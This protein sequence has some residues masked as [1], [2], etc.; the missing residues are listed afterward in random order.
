[1]KKLIVPTVLFMIGIAWF[2][3]PIFFMPAPVH[4]EYSAKTEVD[5]PDM[6]DNAVSNAMSELRRR[7]FVPVK[8]EVNWNPVRKTYG[9]RA[10]GIDRTKLCKYE[11]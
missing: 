1:M 11:P 2:L 9:V 8:L 5:R 6:I 7:D 4:F 10:G 3:F